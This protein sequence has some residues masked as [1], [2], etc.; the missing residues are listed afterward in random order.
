MTETA[1]HAQAPIPAPFVVLGYLLSAIVLQWAVPFPFPWPVALRLLGAVLVI[2]GFALAASAIREM[3]RMHTTPSPRRGVTALVTTGP[4]RFTRNPI[5]LGFFLI[6]LGFTLLAGTL[7][8]IVLSPFLI[9]TVTRW[10]I[11]VEEAYLIDK[12]G[13]EYTAYLLRV[14]RWL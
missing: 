2:A 3:R 8:G 1:D 4:Y 13:D 7:W 11:H 14:R 6:Y 9:G 12:F 5:Y 10:T